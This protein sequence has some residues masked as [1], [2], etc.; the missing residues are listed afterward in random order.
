[1][2]FQDKIKSFWGSSLPRASR[3]ATWGIAIAIFGVWQYQTQTQRVIF[4]EKDLEEWNR[5]AKA[6]AD[7]EGK[8]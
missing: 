8:K 4:S 3:L 1:M 6:K 2:S 5:K 7:L